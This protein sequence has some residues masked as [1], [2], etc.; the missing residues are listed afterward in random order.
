M[1]GL[2][3]LDN[4]QRVGCRTEDSEAGTAGSRCASND[5]APDL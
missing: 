3:P 5:F 4:R 2:P 1:P